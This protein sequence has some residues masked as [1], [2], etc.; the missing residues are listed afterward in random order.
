MVCLL[1]LCALHRV[2]LHRGTGS[3]PSQGQ[4]LELVTSVVMRE[5]VSIILK[6]LKPLDSTAFLMNMLDELVSVLKA[7][8][9]L[10]CLYPQQM[11]RDSQSDWQ[12]SAGQTALFNLCWLSQRSP[13]VT[14]SL[15]CQR[16]CHV[17]IIHR[18][19][20]LLWEQQR[21]TPLVLHCWEARFKNKTSQYLNQLLFPLWAAGRHKSRTVLV[22]ST[23]NIVFWN[24]NYSVQL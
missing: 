9:V 1:W 19:L 10:K 20:L 18:Q 17:L 13:R 24:K 12:G 11:C 23:G 14:A 7:G 3:A 22:C 2:T 16:L 5:C 21:E 8:I 4:K 6:K 15:R